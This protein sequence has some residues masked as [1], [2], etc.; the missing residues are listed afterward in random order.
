[1]RLLPLL[2]AAALLGACEREQ[3]FDAARWKADAMTENHQ[4]LEVR[5]SMTADIERRFRAGTARAEILRTF[6]PGEY[7]IRQGC[8]YPGVDNCLA[9]D[10]GMTGDDYGYLLFAFRGDR[11]AFVLTAAG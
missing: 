9:Y 4:F 6:G 1:M 7:D 2:L 3:S 8:D 10:L 11:L 5:Q